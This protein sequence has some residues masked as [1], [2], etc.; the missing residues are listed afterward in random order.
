MFI[1]NPRVGISNVQII[2]V[3]L[4]KNHI[5]IYILLVLNFFMFFNNLERLSLVYSE[6]RNTS[7]EDEITPNNNILL[8]RNKI[9]VFVDCARNI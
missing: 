8:C 5:Y 7:D 6:V 3:S 4:H 9:A 2:S 1:L